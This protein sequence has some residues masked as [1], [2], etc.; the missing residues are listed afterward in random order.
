MDRLR[1]LEAFVAVVETGTFSAAAE[2]LRVSSVMIGKHMLALE[3]QLNVRLLNRSTR[4]QSLTDVGATFLE[5]AREILRQ[6]RLAQQSIERFQNTPQGRL[7]IS[8]PHTLGTTVLA[9]LMTRY[10]QENPEVYVDVVLSN[11]RVDLIQDRFDLAVRIGPLED[12]R[13]IARPL[14]RYRMVI[15]ASPAYLASAGVPRVPGDLSRHR[16]LCHLALPSGYRWEAGGAEVRWPESATIAS[17][18]GY[19]LRAAA[20]EGAGLI[21]QPEALLA[22]DIDAGRLVRVLDGYAPPPRPVNLLYLEGT[23]SRPKLTRLV[24]MLVGALGD[25]ALLR[26]PPAQGA[27]AMPALVSA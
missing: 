25:T 18:D 27:E 1:D 14:R 22:Q 26:A 3:T 9:P 17:N 11:R 20:L 7:R 15:C 13:L 5:H 16:C 12:S 23:N 4:K 2:R 19:V 6:T 8:A 21:L 10:A 24:D